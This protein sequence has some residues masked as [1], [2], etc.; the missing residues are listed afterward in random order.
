MNTAESASAVYVESVDQ[1]RRGDRVGAVER[2]RAETFAMAGQDPAVRTEADVEAALPEVRGAVE[3]LLAVAIALLDHGGERGSRE[4]AWAVRTIAAELGETEPG[5]REPMAA[6]A[7]RDLSFSLL[8]DCLCRGRLDPLPTLAAVVIPGRYEVQ[9]RPLFQAPDLRHPNA[10]ARGADRAYL[11]WS[12]WLAGTEL[13]GALT[14]VRDPSSYEGAIGEA[15]LVAALC[16]S[17]RDGDRTYCAVI[18]AGGVPERRLRG[19]LGDPGSARALAGF[20]GLGDGEDLVEALNVLYG[21]LAG[22]DGFGTG[23]PLIVSG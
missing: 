12:E 19:R 1:L 7:L 14:H 6:L 9:G 8:A 10:F 18:G 5:P 17:R 20:L 11:S 15:E 21:Q 2:L 4:V 3:R 13:T 23:S 22:S 16:F